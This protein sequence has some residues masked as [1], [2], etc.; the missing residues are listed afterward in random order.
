MAISAINNIPFGTTYQPGKPDQIVSDG[1]VEER[2]QKTGENFIADITDSRVQAFCA[3]QA[4]APNDSW[5]PHPLGGFDSENQSLFVDDHG[6]VVLRSNGE[7]N[8]RHLINAPFDAETGEVSLERSSEGF[9]TARE[10]KSQSF[11]IPLG[12][13]SSVEFGGV[14]DLD[15]PNALGNIFGLK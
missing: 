4:K 15:D 1:K 9:D 10:G 5:T 7:D 6:R 3:D 14:F 8:K 13:A 11:K 12:E 2:F